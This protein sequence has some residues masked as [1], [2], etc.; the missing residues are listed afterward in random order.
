[1]SEPKT[2]QN[3][4]PMPRHVIPASNSPADATTPTP[5]T[6]T[7]PADAPAGIG[8][9]DRVFLLDRPRFVD[10]YPRYL[11]P[12]CLDPGHGGL[13]LCGEGAPAR[14]RDLRLAGF[15]GALVED[16]AAYEKQV[17]TK[18]APFDLPE[19]DGLFEIELEDVLKAQI[20]RGADWAMTPSRYI[21]SGDSPA[22]KALVKRAREIA[23][24]NVIVVVAASIGWLNRDFRGQFTAALQSIGYPVALALGGQYN[25]LRKFA[26]APE[27][28]RDLLQEV[29]GVGLWR[30]D[31]AAFDMLAYGG[32]FAAIGAGG[33][34]RHLV[35]A[36][37]KAESSKPFPHYP[38]VLVPDLLR[39]TTADTLADIYADTDPPPCPCLVCGG[40][41]N[42]EAFHSLK[43]PGRAA[44]HAH[45]AATWT[46]W[47]P[48]I[49]AYPRLADRQSWWR[50]RCQ[51]AVQ[52]HDEENERIGQPGRLK[53]PTVVA[54]WAKL[55]TREQPTTP[56]SPSQHHASRPNCPK[57]AGGR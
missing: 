13:V 49:L 11:G 55:P 37:E 36:G 2:P 45:N 40:K 14:A 8:L 46:T 52:S 12:N 28:L 10:Q 50:G 30:T 29:P 44:A 17:A 4:V 42:L 54:K 16:P 21:L 24:E 5:P 1:M 34:L 19:G 6:A 38:S 23:F 56:P 25:P 27:H 9:T 41:L 57:G 33:S 35:P 51:D 22:L 31:L 39:F 3:G 18:Q 47:L 43:A 20:E 48:E 26:D 53:P 15:T 32:S 7:V